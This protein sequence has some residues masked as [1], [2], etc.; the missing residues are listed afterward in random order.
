MMETIPVARTTTR[1]RSFDPRKVGHYEKENWVAY[2]RKHWPSLLVISV[3][4][5]REAFGLSLLDS[6]RGAYLVARAEIAA[7]PQ[8]ND[9]PL[10]EKYM[11]SFYEL[12]KRKNG[13]TFDVKETAELEVNWWRVHRRL[14]DQEQN[15]PL[16]D[17]LTELYSATY[18]IEPE[19][20]RDAAYHRAQA[21]LYSDKWVYEGC[22][23]HSP[24]LE[25]EEQELV[26]SYTALRDAVQ[27]DA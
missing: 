17:A 13:E 21:M 14:F 27:L 1:M 20:V 23:S 26:L 8:D 11:R 24:L 25:K 16:V 15:G 19:R 3:S 7:A 9:I 5:V 12:V 4:M 10:A 2:Y 18:A 6:I 22:P